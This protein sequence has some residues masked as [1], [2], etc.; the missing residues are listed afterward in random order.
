MKLKISAF[1]K[2]IESMFAEGNPNA[3]MKWTK[4][5]KW[6]TYPT[7]VKGISGDF[8]AEAPEYR[9]RVMLAEY[10][11]KFGYSIR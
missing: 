7:G 2:K 3:T 6:Y 10:D 9:T 1:K 4:A 5:P 8:K 11:D